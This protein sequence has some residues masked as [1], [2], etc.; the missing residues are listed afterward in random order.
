MTGVSRAYRL[1]ELERLL[2]AANVRLF[3]RDPWV[4]PR[5]GEIEPRVLGR[6][7]PVRFVVSQGWWDEFIAPL[8]LEP[9]LEVHYGGYPLEVDQSLPGKSVR[10]LDAEA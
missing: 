3:E 2:G 7:R 9:G 10:V 8:G 1:P 4:N 6:L 5:T